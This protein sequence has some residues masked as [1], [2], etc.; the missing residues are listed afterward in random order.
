VTRRPVVFDCEGARLFGSLDQASG[1]TGL[2]IVSGGNEIRCGAWSGQA[3]LAA[4]LAG[5]GHPVFRFDRRGVGDSEGENLGFRASR[6]DIAAALAAFRREAPGLRRIVAFGNCDA[7]SALMLFA[8]EL[9]LD[10]LIL[11]NPWTVDCEDGGA[12]QAPAVARRRYARKLAD[13][14][15][16]KRLA[17]GGVDFDDLVRGVVKA[18]SRTRPSELAAEMREG[19]ARYPGAVS[20]LI[21]QRDRTAQL[22]LAAWGRDSRTERFA[23]A[24]HSFADECARDWL[25]ERVLAAL[26]A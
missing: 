26:R 17:S 14:R 13:P 3:L 15:Q 9:E 22:F 6:A 5:A 10:G 11:A 4:R 8:A 12:A 16:W 23:T 2:L 24:S 18:L 25:F 21:A 1:E 19:L 7:A 20:I